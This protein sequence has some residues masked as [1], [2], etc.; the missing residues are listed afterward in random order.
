MVKNSRIKEIIRVNQAG[1]FGAKRIY[2][3]QLKALK[4]SDKIRHMLDQ[5]LEHLNKFNEI[6]V[7]RRVRPTIL[8]PIWSIG[9]FALGFLTAKM[10]EKAAMACTVAVEDVIDEHYKNQIDELGDN[11]TELKNTISKFRDEE[12]EHKNTAINEGAEEAPLYPILS[13]GIKCVTRAAIW[14]STRY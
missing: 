13:T 8:N 7:E 2:E 12:I 1:E 10:G 4:K 9:G 3:G 5:E 6:M 11:E 14:L